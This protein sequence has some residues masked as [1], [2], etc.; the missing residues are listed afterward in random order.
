[1][2]S[3]KAGSFDPLATER[4]TAMRSFMPELNLAVRRGPGV[5][6]TTR[7]RACWLERDGDG[8]SA[9]VQ[10]NVSAR[11]EGRDQLRSAVARSPDTARGET[12]LPW[13]QGGRADR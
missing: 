1:M 4:S 3:W 5:C 11:P 7:D 2:G 6:T 10:T 12:D 13:T 8:C 9:T